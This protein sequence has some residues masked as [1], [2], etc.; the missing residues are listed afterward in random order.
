MPGQGFAGHIGFAKE[1]SGG[2]PVAATNYVEAF[3]ENFTFSMDRFETKNITGRFAEPDDEAGVRRL[4]GNIVIPAHP[5][6]LGYFLMGGLG[7]NSQSVVL[8]GFLWNNAFTPRTTDFDSLFSGQ[9]FTFEI[10]RDVTSSARYSGCV[11][12]ALEMSAAPNQDLRVT[13]DLIGKSMSHIAKTTP[14]FTGSPTTPFAFDT[15]SVSIGGTASGQYETFT[16]RFDNQIVGIPTLNNETDIRMMRRQGPQMAR[17]SG[18]FSFEDINEYL[19]FLNQTEQRIVLNFFRASSFNLT[20]DFPR[21][22]YTGFPLGIG[23]RDRVTASFEGMARYHTGSGHAM[24]AL[25]TTT[26]SFF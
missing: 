20:L 16:L 11:V 21:V 12:N 14:T 22:V 24:R 13:V 25:L 19:D 4:V 2:T 8:S 3:S 1:S 23:G 18:A 9:P 26:R 15:C 6:E 10:F 5:H 7:I 17:I